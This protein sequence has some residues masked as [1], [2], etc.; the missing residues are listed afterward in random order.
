[1][2]KIKDV[3]THLTLNMIRCTKLKY[4]IDPQK[5]NGI[6]SE[7]KIKSFMF[8][9]FDQGKMTEQEKFEE[10]FDGETVHIT[11]ALNSGDHELAII[12]QNGKERKYAASDIEN[13]VF[14]GFSS[15]FWLMQNYINLQTKMSSSMIC[16]NMISLKVK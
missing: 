7:S 11:R 10:L 14:G 4:S 9:N 15:R 3:K 2:E 6:K 13:F 16:W 1:M 5:Y 8:P 12:Y